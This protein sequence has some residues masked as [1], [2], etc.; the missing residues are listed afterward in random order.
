MLVT[1]M[2]MIILIISS[3]IIAFTIIL[4]HIVHVLKEMAV[5]CDS[6]A[7]RFFFDPIGIGAFWEG[8]AAIYLTGNG[9]RIFGGVLPGRLLFCT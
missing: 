5:S 6:T 9:P 1:M 8:Y 2:K 3:S 4:L 7:L